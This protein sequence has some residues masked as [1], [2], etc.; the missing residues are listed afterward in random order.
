MR[1]HIIGEI[2]SARAELAKAKMQESKPESP[3]QPGTIPAAKI[4]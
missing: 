3:V 1:K 2:V 4:Y